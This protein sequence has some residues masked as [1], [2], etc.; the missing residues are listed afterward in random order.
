MKKQPNIQIVCAQKLFRSFFVLFMISV[1]HKYDTSINCYR[2]CVKNE[3]FQ[4]NKFYE[5]PWGC[6]TNKHG[7]I[8][9][10]LRIFFYTFLVLNTFEYNFLRKIATTLTHTHTHTLYYIRTRNLCKCKVHL[11]NNKNT[12]ENQAKRQALDH[13]SYLMLYEIN[14]TLRDINR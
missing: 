9:I 8:K 5:K 1:K 3:V 4:S 14:K 12:L 10:T 7:A 6:H 13:V 11:L 2:Q